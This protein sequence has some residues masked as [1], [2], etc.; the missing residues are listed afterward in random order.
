MGQRAA[1]RRTG[2]LTAAKRR[3]DDWR[4]SRGRRGQIPDEL[5]RI[6]VDAAIVHGVHGTARHLRLNA[7]SLRNQM[8]RLGENRPSADTPGFVELPWLQMS[9]TAECILEAEDQAGRKLRIHLKGEA[10]AQAG[11]LGRMLW[12]DKE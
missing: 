1:T 8:E 3:F 12:R 11:P 10:T 2:T 4:R 6:A 5:W 7:T 9:P